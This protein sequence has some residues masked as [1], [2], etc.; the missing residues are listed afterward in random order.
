VEFAPLLLPLLAQPERGVIALVG[1]GGKTAALYRLG[2]ELAQRGPGRHVLLTTTTHLFDPRLESGRLFDQLALVPQLAEAE[3]PAP[4]PPPP[5]IPGRGA[6]VLAAAGTLSA[7]GRLRGILPARV[8]E[9]ARAWPYVVVEADG[10]KRRPVKAPAGHEPALPTCDLVLGAVGLG[11]LGRPMDAAAVHRPELFGPLTGCAPGQPI[12]VEHLAE[13]C[14][15]PQGL[16]K[17]VRPGLPRV[18]LLNQADRFP[19]DRM[20]LLRALRDCAD[21]VL[22]ASLAHPDPAARILAVA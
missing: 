1:A 15:A 7:E 22:L 11:C 2:E 10:S 16:F 20:A 3:G 17:G 9:L 14:F 13:L 19:G 8:A 21:R 12:G 4:L 6:R 5:A 18:L